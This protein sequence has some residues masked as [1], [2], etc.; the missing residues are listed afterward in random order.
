MDADERPHDEMRETS[1][2]P[3]LIAE[4]QIELLWCQLVRLRPP[5]QMSPAGLAPSIPLIGEAAHELM[6]VSA[7]ESLGISVSQRRIPTN[8]C[9]SLDNQRALPINAR[10]APAGG[11]VLA[12]LIASEMISLSTI[13]L[14]CVAVFLS[15][16]GPIPR[17]PKQEPFGD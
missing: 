14:L 12:R 5:Q 15:R 1:R 13:I 17:P 11:R 10:Q 7:A 2:G 8:I 6:P 4:E 3:G 16:L 9:Q